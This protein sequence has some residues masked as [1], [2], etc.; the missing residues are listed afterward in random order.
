M[1]LKNF[2]RGKYTGC[3]CLKRGDFVC[4][5]VCFVM[6]LCSNLT[7]FFVLHKCMN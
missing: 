1:R 5:F 7:I 4:F 2:T 6:I 3:Y